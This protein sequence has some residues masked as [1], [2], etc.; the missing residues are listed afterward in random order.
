MASEVDGIEGAV[1]LALE[2]LDVAVEI[3]DAVVPG[4]F[5]EAATGSLNEEGLDFCFIC[6]GRKYDSSLGLCVKMGTLVKSLITSSIFQD[7]PG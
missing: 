6:S 4:A 3:H 1:G 2:G 7:S 5:L